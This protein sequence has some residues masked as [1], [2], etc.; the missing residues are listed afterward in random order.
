M[1]EQSTAAVLPQDALLAKE[2]L[3][4][5]ASVWPGGSVSLAVEMSSVP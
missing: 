3:E 2:V 5:M 1:A 4:S